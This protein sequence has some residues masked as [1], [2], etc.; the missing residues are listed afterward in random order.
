[1]SHRTIRFLHLWLERNDLLDGRP[2]D[3]AA[4]G[5]YATR[6]FN[7]AEAEGI[8]DT[9]IEDSW[10]ELHKGLVDIMRRRH[11]APPMPQ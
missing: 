5:R 9:E 2:V 6:L 10:D 7:D 1:M 11:K 8:S 4:I 3:D